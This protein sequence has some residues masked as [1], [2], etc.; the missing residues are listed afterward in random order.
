MYGDGDRLV[1][2]ANS[3]K[4]AAAIPGARTAVVPGANHVLTSDQPQLVNQ[5]LL[6]WFAAHEAS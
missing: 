1:V 3:E 4:I 6:D 2:P 5:L